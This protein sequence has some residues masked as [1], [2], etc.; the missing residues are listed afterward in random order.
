MTTTKKGEKKERKNEK[1]NDKLTLSVELLR[2]RAPVNR[3]Y[4]LTNF[5]MGISSVKSHTNQRKTLVLQQHTDE[6]LE[7]PPSRI[8]EV[9]SASVIQG[10][11]SLTSLRACHTPLDEPHGNTAGRP[12]QENP[13]TR[14]VADHQ[15]GC[16][17]T[18][19]AIRNYQLGKTQETDKI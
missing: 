8:P 6:R 1:N 4:S 11:R 15:L 18:L 17:S 13:G 10:S 14:R 7:R 3:T 5:Q 12:P 19:A 9:P 16:R 2:C